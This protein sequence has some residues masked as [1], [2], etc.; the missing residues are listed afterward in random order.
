MRHAFRR[1]LARFRAAV[2]ATDASD[3]GRWR[4]LQGR[5]PLFA[6]VLHHHHHHHEA[7]DAGLRPLLTTRLAAAGDGAALSVLHD[8]EAEHASIDPTWTRRALP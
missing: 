6:T 3:Q 2:H 8:M 4:A 1:D 7:E 5:W